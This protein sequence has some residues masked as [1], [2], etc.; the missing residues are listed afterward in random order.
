[1]DNDPRRRAYFREVADPGN[2]DRC[3]N[4][5]ESKPTSPQILFFCGKPYL[6]RLSHLF[7]KKAELAARPLEA[8]EGSGAERNRNRQSG[9]ESP[10]REGW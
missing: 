1:M 8:M 3:S 4:S 5:A 2:Q 7:H 10:A 9:A 6:R